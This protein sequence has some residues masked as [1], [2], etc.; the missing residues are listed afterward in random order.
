MDGGRGTYVRWKFKYSKGHAYIVKQFLQIFSPFGMITRVPYA[1]AIAMLAT[2]GAGL[3]LWG[4]LE[5][6]IGRFWPAP[7]ALLLWIFLATL[8][9]RLKDAGR[10]RGWI[11]VPLALGAGAAALGFALYN[12]PSLMDTMSDEMR[13]VAV[14]TMLPVLLSAA[15]QVFARLVF[16]GACL[17]AVWG[18]FALA[19]LF[20]RS[21]PRG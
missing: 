18:V 21:Q 19:L 6:T 20:A 12:P 17:A 16:A 5:K 3:A 13:A 9:K 14:I 8:V 1:C 10:S 7:F 15:G 2:L 11:V 4:D